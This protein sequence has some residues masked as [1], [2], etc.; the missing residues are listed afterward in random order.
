M[1]YALQTLK[2]A[3]IETVQRFQLLKTEETTD[4]DKLFFA[5]AENGFRG[6]IKFRVENLDNYL[7]T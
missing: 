7:D 2:L 4:E 1:R 6:G 5:F 3:I